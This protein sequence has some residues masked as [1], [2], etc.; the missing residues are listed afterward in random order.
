MEESNYLKRVLEQTK[1]LP[2]SGE[3][4]IIFDNISPSSVIFTLY[5]TE[6]DRYIDKLISFRAIDQKSTADLITKSIFKDIFTPE[7][8]PRF[9][10]MIDVKKKLNREKLEEKYKK[11]LSVPIPDLFSLN[12]DSHPSY[13]KAEIDGAIMVNLTPKSTGESELEG[14]AFIEIKLFTAPEGDREKIITK[15]LQRKPLSEYFKLRHI[16]GL[17]GFSYLH[18]AD[19]IEPIGKNDPGL[20]QRGK[21]EPILWNIH[22]I[23]MDGGILIDFPNAIKRAHEFLKFIHKHDKKLANEEYDRKKY[24]FRLTYNLVKVI[25]MSQTIMGLQNKIEEA[26]KRVE[27]E[28]KRAEEAEE[29]AEEEKKRVEEEKKRAEKYRQKLIES[30]IDPDS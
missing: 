17:I 8:S 22:L 24:K 10:F 23:L 21:Q 13:Y 15:R 9:N 12:P 30:G 4:T 7:S 5:G 11:T 1:N 3:K 29:R 25:K 6:I 27:E 14:Y 19:N 28:K 16:F 2:N 26:E 20:Q 18:R